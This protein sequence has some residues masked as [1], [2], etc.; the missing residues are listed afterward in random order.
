MP[1]I[2]PW[3]HIFAFYVTVC[4]RNV[5]SILMGEATGICP[6][7]LG[8][9]HFMVPGQA[10]NYTWLKSFSLK[11]QFYEI[12]WNLERNNSIH[13][14][15]ILFQ[16]RNTSPMANQSWYLIGL[17]RFSDTSSFSWLKYPTAMFIIEQVLSSMQRCYSL[18]QV[19]CNQQIYAWRIHI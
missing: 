3:V 16:N 8:K 1:Y 18:A 6:S 15:N 7:T 10:V 2:T 4:P 14:S 11:R 17:N 12:Y 13:F 9:L 5:W 19:N